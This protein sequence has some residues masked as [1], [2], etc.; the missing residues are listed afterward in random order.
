MLTV[1][2]ARLVWSPTV[3]GAKGRERWMKLS[4]SAAMLGRTEG[5]VAYS[6]KERREGGGRRWFRREMRQ[7]EG[8]EEKRD[9]SRGRFAM[10]FRQFSLPIL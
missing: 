3:F 1:S 4:V 9:Q 8:G 10:L 2:G 7:Q 5:I 6:W